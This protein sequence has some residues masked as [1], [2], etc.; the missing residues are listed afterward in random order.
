MMLVLSPTRFYVR[1]IVK[2]HGGLKITCTKCSSKNPAQFVLANFAIP[3]LPKQTNKLR[4][5][6]TTSLWEITSPKIQVRMQPWLP[7]RLLPLF[8][9]KFQPIRCVRGVVRPVASLCYMLQSTVTHTHSIY[10][11]YHQCRWSFSRKVIVVTVE[12][13]KKSLKACHKQMT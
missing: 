3:I 9:M 13:P 1:V 2:S 6:C 5:H 10:I 12:P 4:V 7:K 8:N 11:H